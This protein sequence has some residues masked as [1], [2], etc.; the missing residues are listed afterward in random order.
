MW[1]EETQGRPLVELLPML[2]IDTYRDLIDTRTLLAFNGHIPYRN[3]TVSRYE[4]S[5][6]KKKNTFLHY[7][8]LPDEQV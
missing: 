4:L 8:G 5:T 3:P 6:S 2:R 7:P 1:T